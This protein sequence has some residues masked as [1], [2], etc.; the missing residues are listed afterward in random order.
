[1]NITLIGPRSVGKTTISK[2]VSKKL[3]LKYISSDK[4]GEKAFKK[5]GGLDQ[6]IKSGKIKEIINSG[7]YTLIIKN[8]NKNNNFIF[9]LSAGAFTSKSMNKASSE[10][11]KIAK[12]KS[13]IVGLLPCKNK[14]QSILF[15][16]NR[17]RKRIHFKNSNKLKLFIKTFRKYPF[18]KQI[19]LKNSDLMIYT[20]GKSPEEISK[21]IVDKIKSF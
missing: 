9:D 15:L 1:M 11:R 10:V 17:E 5:Y 6:V 18:I 20:K 13:I 2:I 16:F 7:G 14:F 21:E 8:Y 4:L 19:I 12:K 3:K